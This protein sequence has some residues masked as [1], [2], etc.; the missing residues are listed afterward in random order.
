MN[1]T[2]SER[3][4][5]FALVLGVVLALALSFRGTGNT[6]RIVH[7]NDRQKDVAPAAAPVTFST[8][9]STDWSRPADARLALDAQT[10]L[11]ERIAEAH[12]SGWRIVSTTT[13]MRTR[14][15]RGA[16]LESP[17]ARFERVF[18]LQLPHERQAALRRS[19]E[20]VQVV[21]SGSV[22]ATQLPRVTAVAEEVRYA[23]DR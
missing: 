15:E 7:G 1:T 19:L 13:H 20:S 10:A 21:A 4:G 18:E 6:D 22:G 8:A 2:G 12:G 3:A 17:V 9:Y 23:A 16:R 11:V 5:A 14:G